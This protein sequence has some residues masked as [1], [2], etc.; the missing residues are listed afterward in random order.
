MKYLVLLAHRG[1][2]WTDATDDQRTAWHQDH[3]NFHQA[4]GAAMLGGE[5]L[6]GT[7]TAT[8]MRR[9]GDHWA[10]TDGPF[11]ELAEVIG[12]FYLLEAN[13]LDQVARWCELLPPPY[14]IEIRPCV[15]V[16]GMD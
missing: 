4:V 6:A 12:G 3:L 2:G 5:A 8:T 13:D 16:E 11:A 15:R 1:N 10:L 9:E 7:D 14:T